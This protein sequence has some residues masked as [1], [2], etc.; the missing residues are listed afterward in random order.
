MRTYVSALF[1]AVALSGCSWWNTKPNVCEQAPARAAL[2][3]SDPAPLTPYTPAWIVVTPGNV[4]SVW[5]NLRKDSKEPVLF[6]LTD[7]DYEQLSVDFAEVRNFIVK[8]RRIT[9]EYREYYEPESLPKP[10]K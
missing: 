9:Q 4:E 7:G 8:Q 2:N 6:G 1:I 5:A 3:L 10:T